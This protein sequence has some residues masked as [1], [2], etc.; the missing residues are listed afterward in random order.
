MHAT[1][2]ATPFRKTNHKTY[3]T[4][5]T[6]GGILSAYLL[7]T[8]LIVL[9]L[10]PCP[11]DSEKC[12]MHILNKSIRP[13]IESSYPLQKLEEFVVY[14]TVAVQMRKAENAENDNML[15]MK[16]IEPAQTEWS[17]PN[18]ICPINELNLTASRRLSKIDAVSTRDS[19]PLPQMDEYIDSLADANIIST[20]DANSGYW[21]IIVPK[22]DG[23]K[24]ASTWHYGWYE[25]T[26]IVLRLHNAPL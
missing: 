3:H 19:Y 8:L 26:R 9:D 23:E 11:N 25:I 18:L 13:P 10:S 4:I 2:E 16:L 14:R 1:R 5:A 21:K 24:I 17:S 7:N 12:G 6:I 22:S 20:I 15:E